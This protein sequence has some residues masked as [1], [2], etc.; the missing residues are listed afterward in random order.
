MKIRINL[1]FQGQIQTFSLET[2]NW[3]FLGA[4]SNDWKTFKFIIISFGLKNTQKKKKNKFK[5]SFLARKVL[6]NQLIRG[7]KLTEGGHNN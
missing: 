4:N 7:E 2:Q 5:D 6:K 3:D 1:K